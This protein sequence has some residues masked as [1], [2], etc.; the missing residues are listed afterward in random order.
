M[1]KR[2]W[3]AGGVSGVSPPLFEGSSEQS[4]PLKRKRIP[5]MPKKPKAKKHKA[6]SKRPMAKKSAPAKPAKRAAGRRTSWLDERTQSP[7]I[8]ELAQQLQSFLQT[9]ADGQVDAA[10]IEAQE[11]RLVK[12]MKT[13][14]PK[15]NDQQHGLVTELLCELTAYD[16]MQM[17]HTMQQSKPQ[18]T[19]RG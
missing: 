17:L 9:M 14:E 13:V 18:T 6:S 15:L 12:L 2:D 16:L 7:R 10:E 4:A 8:N 19:F 5:F 1:I 11:Q 3:R